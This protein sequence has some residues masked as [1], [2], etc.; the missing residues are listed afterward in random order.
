[1]NLN[2]SRVLLTGAAG[3]IGSAIAEQLAAKG[4]RLALLGRTAAELNRLSELLSAEHPAAEVHVVA[5]DLLDAAAREHAVAQ[6]S[7]LLGGIDLLINCAGLMSFRPFADEDPEVLERIVQLNLVAPMRLI[8]QVLPAML[9]RGSGRIVNV[10]STFGSIGFAWFAAY[11]ASKFGLRGLSESLRR[12]LEG[13]GVG[14]T[15]VAPRAVKTPLNTDAVYRM[16]R[17]TK[18]PMDDP[19][20]V[21]QRT[22][23]A[24]EKDAKDVYL[25]FPEKFFA[26]LNSF[27]PRVVDGG[28]RK[29][30]AVMAPFARDH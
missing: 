17:A 3:G 4:A 11:S 20:W 16:A 14:V 24:I 19:S 12:E 1:M 29:Q 21:A 15:Y 25:G 30:N 13:S 7:G 23:A 6:A 22:I 8:R 28:L 10:G 18:M 5:V 26:R 9:A 27:V 2:G